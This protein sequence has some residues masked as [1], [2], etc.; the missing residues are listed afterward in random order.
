MQ[1][2]NNIKKTP[3][4]MIIKKLIKMSESYVSDIIDINNKYKIPKIIN[5][6]KSVIHIIKN[7]IIR[8]VIWER[9][10]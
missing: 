5:I 9:K 7:N 8:I 6:R 2:D 3:K 1:K 10:K 4:S